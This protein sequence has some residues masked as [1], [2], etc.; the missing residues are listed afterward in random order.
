MFNLA[1][2]SSIRDLCCELA[3]DECA[4]DRTNYWTDCLNSYFV[5]Y[6]HDHPPTLV[7]LDTGCR[8]QAWKCPK[9]KNW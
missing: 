5:P 1:S 9:M 7:K 8:S 3:N 4:N 6:T 2:L